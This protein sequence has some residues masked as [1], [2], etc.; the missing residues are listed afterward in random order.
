MSDDATSDPTPSLAD[1]EALASKDLKGRSPN[2]LTRTRPAD[3][4]HLRPRGPVVL[5]QVPSDEAGRPGD[6]DALA[7]EERSPFCS[8]ASDPMPYRK[9]PL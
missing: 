7:H 8:P 9:R 1:W 3:E 6:H 5:L 2:D 4:H